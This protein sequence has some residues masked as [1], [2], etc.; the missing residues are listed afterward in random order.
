MENCVFCKI[1][2]GEIS[3]H[4]VFENEK[5]FAFLDISPT[6]YGHTLIVPKKHC[7]DLLTADIETL[8][9]L[10]AAAQKIGAAAQKSLSCGG[11]NIIQNNGAAA[12]QVVGHLHFHIIPRKNDD[13]LRHW[14]GGKY[15]DGEAAVIAEKIV[16]AF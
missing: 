2:S 5:V 16:S 13:G 6:T 14:L 7:V 4:K 11:F 9:A 8:T 3:C 15:G 12:G 1:I 10:M